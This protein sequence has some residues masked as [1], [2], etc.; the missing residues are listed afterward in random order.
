MR[1]IFVSYARD[2]ADFVALLCQDLDRLHLSVWI[3]Q[4]LVGGQEWWDEILT[5]I[6]DCDAFILA[7]SPTSIESEACLL[8]VRYAQANGRRFIPVKVLPTPNSHL[9][10]EMDG[11]EFVDYTTDRHSAALGI[12]AAISELPAS[13]PPPDPPPS[14]PAI[15]RDPFYEVA[16]LLALKEELNYQR[17]VF[18]LETLQQ[19]I[20][21]PKLRAEALEFVDE[22]RAR[23]WVMGDILQ[24]LDLLEGQL[25]KGEPSPS[26]PGTSWAWAPVAAIGLLVSILAAAELFNVHTVRPIELY[27]CGLDI[28]LAATVAWLAVRPRPRVWA[29]WLLL[30]A[31]AIDGFWSFIYPY[32]HSYL[33]LNLDLTTFGPWVLI[34]LVFIGLRP[35]WLA[36]RRS[37]IDASIAASA[38][39]G[40]FFTIIET[41]PSGWLHTTGHGAA[42]CASLVLGAAVWVALERGRT[43][44]FRLSAG[45]AGLLVVLYEFCVSRPSWLKGNPAWELL[46]WEVALVILASIAVYCAARWTTA[47]GPGPVAAT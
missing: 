28:G 44:L 31:L 18:I 47:Q 8:E 40:A 21:R 39:L 6:R 32:D 45:A 11:V 4:V 14:P 16:Q 43:M 7:L 23:Q 24:R 36:E 15:P 3:D 33:T 20:N 13:N 29:W 26:T 41:V 19:A 1:K 10:R 42:G 12:A 30:A 22:L 35:P 38:A 37:V 9:P 46:L 27:R 34:L 2:D 25:R 17:Q 5:N